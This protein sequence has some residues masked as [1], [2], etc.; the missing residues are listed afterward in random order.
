[1]LAGETGPGGRMPVNCDGGALN[2]GRVHGAN[3]LIEVVHQLRGESGD[4]Q[5][6]DA[7]V[8]VVSNAVGP[9]AGALLLSAQD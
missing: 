1:V 8:G 4:R 9:F 6:P 7:R 2:V 3:H 5:V